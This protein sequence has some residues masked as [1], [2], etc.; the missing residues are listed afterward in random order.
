MYSSALKTPLATVIT[1]TTGTGVRPKNFTPFGHNFFIHCLLGD[2]TA[3]NNR[4]YDG[5]PYFHECQATLEEVSK[6]CKAVS[7]VPL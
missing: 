5:S 2:F 6:K 7:S 1:C 4:K 3:F